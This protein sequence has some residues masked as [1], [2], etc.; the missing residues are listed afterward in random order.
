MLICVLLSSNLH[1]F[2]DLFQSDLVMSSLVTTVFNSSIGW[3]VNKGREV[4]AEKLKQG[5]VTDQKIRDL[6]VREVEDIK[7][8]L[9]GLSRQDLLAAVDSFE[10]GIRYLFKAL[11]VKPIGQVSDATA[12]TKVKI[13]AENIDELSLA[14]TVK[15]KVSAAAEM[16][17]KSE[18][19]DFDETTKITFSHAEKR[20]QMAREMATKAFNNEALKFF[21]RITAIRYRIMATMLESVVETA[22]TIGDLSS[23]SV[24][25]ALENALPECYQCLQIL[26]SAPVVQ[27][28]FKVEMEK[29][30]LNLRRLFGTDERREIISSV[31]QINRAIYNATQEVGKEE[32]A[33]VCPAIDIGEDK[34]DL[35]RDERAL[36]VIRDVN[37]AH[38]SVPWSF[39]QEGEEDHKLKLPCAIATN[40]HGHFLIVDDTENEVKVF[41]SNGKY[42]FS[43]K[44]SHDDG[45]PKIVDVETNVDEKIYLLVSMKRPGAEERQREVQVLT[46]TADLQYKFPVKG[47]GSGRIRLIVNGRKVLL[48]VDNEVYVYEQ[49]GEFLFR[50]GKGLLSC[51]RDIASFDGRVII[52]DEEGLYSFPAKI[53]TW[54]HIFTMEGQHLDKFKVNT[55]GD[56][57]YRIA[58]HPISG[59][60]VAAGITLD[61]IDLDRDL[62]TIALYTVNG[63]FVRRIQLNENQRSILRPVKG[64]T[65]TTKGDIAVASISNVNNY[66]NMKVIVL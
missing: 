17:E 37:M 2:T 36:Q 64:L 4:T 12:E 31:C 10:T 25:I 60:V 57:Y 27:S 45:Y 8:K 22:G 7:S 61:T 11:D 30:I 5:D 39:G 59:H 19:I 47:G 46:K 29:G 40:I 14:N 20:F 62:L 21:D 6:I 15:A 65:V 23:S 41:D 32:H 24:K 35:L 49:N 1:G 42:D 44:A 3:L 13:A 50:F 43:F 28:C 18:N 56:I 66:Y 33:W 52:L 34:V 38:C 53:D 51:A 26:H 48:L 54:A 55:E 16:R 9:D 63:D 58:C